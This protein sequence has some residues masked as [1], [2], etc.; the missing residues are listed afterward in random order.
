MRFVTRLLIAAYLIEAGI[1]L[2]LA[3]WSP[4][5][6]DRN[7]FGGLPVIAALMASDYV[8]G[9]VSGVG[10]LTALAG[11]RD[12]FALIFGRSSRTPPRAPEP[13]YLADRWPPG[14]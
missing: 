9:A 2:I 7:R 6:W 14:P 1:L 10:V 11:L 8:R 3:P 13:R 4:Y 12:L 5:F